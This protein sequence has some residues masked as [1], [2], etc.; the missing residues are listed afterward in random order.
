MR[1]AGFMLAGAC[2]LALCAAT[3]AGAVTV[4]GATI[5]GA[6][7]GTPSAGTGTGIFILSDDETSLSYEISFSG[8][9]APETVSHFHKA[10][11]GVSGG[12]VKNLPLGS[13]KIG[14]WSAS[15]ATQPLTAQSVADLK[16]GLLYINIHSSSYPGGEIRG[17]IVPEPSSLAALAG[18][19][20]G[21]LGL[22]RRRK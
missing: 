7:S 18:A 9:L 17:Q 4:F 19:C 12:V 5:D 15:D 11:P 3:P 1:I 10:P 20:V 16:A 13:P 8:L 14:V 2:A 22:N 6:Q 21:L